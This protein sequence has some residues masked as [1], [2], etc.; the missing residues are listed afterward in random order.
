MYIYS[1]LFRYRE[2]N[3]LVPAK[4]S[5]PRRQQ[6]RLFFLGIFSRFTSKCGIAAEVS[7]FSDYQRFWNNFYRRV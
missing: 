7:C 3:M 1:A 6:L 4:T 5:P 2:K